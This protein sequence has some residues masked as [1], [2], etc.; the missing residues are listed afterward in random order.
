MASKGSAGEVPT[1]WR[2]K[3]AE[4]IHVRRQA[5]AKEMRDAEKDFANVSLCLVYPLGK[6]TDAI[7]L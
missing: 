7:M 6:Y 3:A 2:A 1:S 5:T 4:M